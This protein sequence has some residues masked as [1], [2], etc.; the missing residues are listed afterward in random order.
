MKKDASSFVI[1]NI[2]IQKVQILDF[3]S[4]DNRSDKTKMWYKHI[5]LRQFLLTKNICIS[6][7]AADVLKWYTKW[8]ILLLYLYL[9]YLLL[10][11]CLY[12][13]CVIVI[14]I[15]YLLYLYLWYLLSYYILPFCRGITLDAQSVYHSEYFY[16][17][18]HD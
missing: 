7:F 5:L 16:K 13:Y 12:T 6:S 8:F 1:K 10:Y 4:K 15:V 14:F 3:I 9:W 18:I 2:I 17:V 11:L